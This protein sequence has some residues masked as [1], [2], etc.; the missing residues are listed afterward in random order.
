MKTKIVGCFLML[1]GLGI[2]WSVHSG[3]KKDRM[4]YE[5]LKEDYVR[6]APFSVYSGEGNPFGSGTKTDL[7]LKSREAELP[8]ERKR[9]DADVFRRQKLENTQTSKGWKETDVRFS[10]KVKGGSRAI[11]QAE[12]QTETRLEIKTETRWETKIDTRWETQE[13]LDHRIPV[14]FIRKDN[15]ANNI[16]YTPAEWIQID[17]PALK[18]LNPDI[19]AWLL[20]PALSLS[21]P[22][23]QGEDNAY[24]L[25]RSF[26]REGSYAGCIFL[27]TRNSPDFQDPFT[28]IYGHNM[29][30]GSMF[31]SLRNL[32]SSADG[33]LVLLRMQDYGIYCRVSSVKTVQI[34]DDRALFPVLPWEACG[35]FSRENGFCLDMPLPPVVCLI[36]CTNHSEG[37]E[38][39]AVFCEVNSIKKD[40]LLSFSL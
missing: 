20:I 9:T 18:M 7:P 22:V 2:A 39:L 37:G 28:L 25:H 38:R 35:Y 8:G 10:G 17:W 12:A 21:Y 15:S 3:Y 4:E 23:V 40:A 13:I 31:G 30:D 27:D 24:Y 5:R 16:Q 26:Q 36:T 33:E 32:F 29:R 6:E 11:I 19:T 1:L 14:H 34:R